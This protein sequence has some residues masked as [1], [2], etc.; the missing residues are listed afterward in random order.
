MTKHDNIFDFSC[1]IIQLESEVFISDHS[2]PTVKDQ[3]AVVGGMICMEQFANP[4]ASSEVYIYSLITRKLNYKVAHPQQ[5]QTAGSHLTVLADNSILLSGG[6]GKKF[7]VLTFKPM[8]PEVCF[9]WDQE[10]LPYC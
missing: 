1:E 10:Y 2:I 5:Y 6:F 9:H 3:L 7:T 4:Q 8:D